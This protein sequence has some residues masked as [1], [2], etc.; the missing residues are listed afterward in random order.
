MTEKRDLRRRVNRLF[1]IIGRSL[2]FFTGNCSARKVSRAFA[3]AFYFFG[4]RGWATA[5][6]HV[7][8]GG[9]LVLAKIRG[10]SLSALCLEPDGDA[11]TGVL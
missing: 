7:H 2:I 8:H 6:L 4:G 1:S 3:I 9:P 10:C 11:P 5:T